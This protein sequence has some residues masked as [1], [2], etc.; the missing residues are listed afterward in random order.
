MSD[1]DKISLSR[2]TM[3]V[4]VPSGASIL[5]PKGTEVMI[6]QSLGD[7]LTLNVHGNLVRI[8]AKNADA[9]GK[10]VSDSL[11]NLPANASIQDKVWAQLRTV[12]DPEIPVN[13]VDL[14]L[15]YHCEFEKLQKGGYR[16]HVEMTL[17]APGCGMG[18][19]LVEDVKTKV[20][21]VAEVSEVEVELVFDP[22]W[23]R[24]KMSEAAQLELGLL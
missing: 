7:S 12:Y 14:G 24:D 10:T 23:D 1:A 2:D 19:V 9:L 20:S 22:P 8:E 21:S 4:L 17:T 13:I 6:T 5:L 16:I 3:G 11:A 18:P 15:I